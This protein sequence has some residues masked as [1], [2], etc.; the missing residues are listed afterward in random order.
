MYAIRKQRTL[1]APVAIEGFGFWTGRDVRVEFRPAET[2]S[3]IVFVRRDLP[4]APRI[5]ALVANRIETPRRTTLEA[6]G[7]SVEMVEHI[8]AALAG[9]Q[10][11]NCEV[12]VDEAEMPGCDGSSQPFVALLESAGIVE[13][14]A[15]RRVL[16][17][18]NTVRLG[19]DESWVEARPSTTGG[20]SIKFRLD[21][22]NGNA[23][24]RQSLQLAITPESF[25]RELAASRT[26]MLEEEAQWLLAQGLGQR[27]TYQ[28]LLIFD[29]NGP[30]QNQLRFRD[31]CV[32]HKALDLL[33][34][35][36]LTGCDIVGHVIAH[37]SGHRLNAELVRALLSEEE[38]SESLKRSA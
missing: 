12:W 18:R 16:V 3:G 26:F 32:R 9:L 24:G 6:A 21:Y 14:D 11:D 27:T 30:I 5:A 19:D 22:G 31:E 7:G 17:I 37:R 1:S 38:T 35:L 25:R 29:K 28:N 2:G 10:I 4:R 23:I 34:D 13:Q 36:A 20:M 33:G 15:A 8:M